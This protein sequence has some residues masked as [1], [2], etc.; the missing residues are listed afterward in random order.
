[1]EKFK[2]SKL[3]LKAPYEKGEKSEIGKLLSGENREVI[4]VKFEYFL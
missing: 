2:I 3:C 4:R 1:M